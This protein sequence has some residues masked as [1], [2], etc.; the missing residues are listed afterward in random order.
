MFL[1]WLETIKSQ[2]EFG[3]QAPRQNF[4]GVQGIDRNPFLTIL[5]HPDFGSAWGPRDALLKTPFWVAVASRDSLE[6]QRSRLPR[7]SQGG[8]LVY[9]SELQAPL[10]HIDSKKV[11]PQCFHAPL[12]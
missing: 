10:W 3:G 5:D 12:V 2:R 4:R 7:G 8:G 1:E 11:A 9:P 6:G